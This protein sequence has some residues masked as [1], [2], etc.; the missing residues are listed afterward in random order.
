[1]KK[2]VLL[3][4]VVALAAGGL[5]ACSGKV[6]DFRNA[7]MSNGKLYA[8]GGNEPFTG[9]FTNVPDEKLV[10][11]REGLASALLPVKNLWSKYPDF[12]NAILNTASICDANYKEGLADGA[13]VCREPT[14][15]DKALR[16]VVQRRTA[17]RPISLV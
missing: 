5:A 17:F 8:R 11:D 14:F 13:S 2:R 4:V 12:T 7:E 1:M 3:G 6:L 16:P 10:T 9:R 15:K